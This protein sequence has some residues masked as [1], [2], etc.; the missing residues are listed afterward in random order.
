MEKTLSANISKYRK[1]NKLTQEKLAGMLGVSFQAVSKWETGQ[2]FPDLELIPKLAAVFKV[3]ID[4]LLGYKTEKITTTHY[5]EKYKDEGLYW[6]NE[7][8]SRCYD[9]LKLMPP[10]KPLRLLDI[11][12]G[13]GQVAVFFARNGYMVSALDIAESGIE[14]GK[15]LA[16]DWAVAV[17][18]FKADIRH[19]KIENQYDVIYASGLLQYIPHDERKI[20]IDN[21]K[22]N[23]ALNGIHVLNVFVDKPFIE[24]A[25]DWEDNEYFWQS[26]E[27]FQYYSD[28]K[29]EIMEEVIFDCNSSGKWHKHC[30]DVLIARKTE[31]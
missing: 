30:M 3:S 25:P 8:W 23:T 1:I 17:D 4:T 9:V 29:F 15:Q 31:S 26:G 7:L 10:T 22:H 28:W 6:G 21:M 11:G 20:I 13:E 5:E 14:K 24:K 27:L 12:C 16:Q 18:F 19:Y 2:S